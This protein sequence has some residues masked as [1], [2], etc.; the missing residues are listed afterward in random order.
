[1]LSEQLGREV[2]AVVVT[3]EEWE[4]AES[5]FLTEVRRRPLVPVPLQ[6]TGT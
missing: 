1:M 4:A 5:G 3:P 2:N 6:D